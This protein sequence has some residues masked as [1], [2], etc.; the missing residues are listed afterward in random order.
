MERRREAY[1]VNLKVGRLIR[2]L[3]EQAEMSQAE[4]AEILG[5]D[6]SSVSRIENGQQ[7]VYLDS[8]LVLARQFNVSP[9]YFLE[10]L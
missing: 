2:K 8:L 6:S 5:L 1:E 4:I 10:G 9:K 7:G 3:R